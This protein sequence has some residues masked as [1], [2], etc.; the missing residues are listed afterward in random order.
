MRT[1]LK[2]LAV[3]TLALAVV[4]AT[5]CDRLIGAAVKGAAEKATGV[6]VDEQS[7]S[8]TFK[9]E[10]GEATVGEGATLPDGF[11][12]EVPVYDGDITTS[13]KTTDAY[14]VGI[15]TS[16]SPSEVFDWYKDALST[17]GWTIKQEI[18]TDTG[19]N[20]GAENA[21][22]TLVISAGGGD[23]EKTTL[24]ISVTKRKK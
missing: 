10:G 20:I 6:S 15:D 9:G 18:K 2:L 14:T 22:W 21:D 19:A 3:A 7:N 1:C 12:E 5:G 23:G 17:E 24:V 13:L 4:G 16:D 8:V 11:P